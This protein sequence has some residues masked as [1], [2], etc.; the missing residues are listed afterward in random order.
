MP[1]PSVFV[2]AQQAFERCFQQLR[3]GYGAALERVVARRIAFVAVALAVALGS[4]AIFLFLGRDY[5]PEIP[6]GT[7]QL[8]MRAP[9]GTRIEVTGRIAT[10]VS[11][12]IEELLPDKVENIVSNCGL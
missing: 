11:K 9:L 5:F 6:S 3:E 8:H 2:R 7:L 12:S 1:D 4:L 10:L